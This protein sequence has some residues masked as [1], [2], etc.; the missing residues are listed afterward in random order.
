[1]NGFSESILGLMNK[2]TGEVVGLF[3]SLQDLEQAGYEVTTSPYIH[4]LLAC[5]GDE[6]WYVKIMERN[7]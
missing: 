7:E 3:R 2:E 4:L 5:R 6:E 1:M